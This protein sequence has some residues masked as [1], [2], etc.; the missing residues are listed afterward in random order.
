MEI[1]ITDRFSASEI[2]ATI[3]VVCMLAEVFVPGFVLFPLGLAFLIT[4]GVALM[5]HNWIILLAMLAATEVVLFSLSNKYIRGRATRPATYT[6]AEGMIGKECT[7]TE[8]ITKN[9]TGYIK[10]YGDRWQAV[11][12]SGDA[13]KVGSRVVITGIDGNKVIVANIN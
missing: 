5:T 2:L 1:I 6:N 8:S 9:G 12:E 4:A 10:L 3:G 7:V 11:C 13:I